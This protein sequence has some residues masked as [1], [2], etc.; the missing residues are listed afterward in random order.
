MVDVG[1]NRKDVKS[2]YIPASQLAA[3]NSL[4]GGANIILIGKLIKETG[5]FSRETFKKV[6]EKIVPP[7]KEQLIANNL[8][9]VE[10]GFNS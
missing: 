3:D 1:I 6:I 4:K 8:K 10:I 7:A 9:A 5:I 2:F